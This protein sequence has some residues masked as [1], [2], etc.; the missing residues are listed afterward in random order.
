M[1]FA[2]NKYNYREQTFRF[3]ARIRIRISVHRVLLY[4][5]PDPRL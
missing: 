4:Y 2:R 1:I 5:T 3:A